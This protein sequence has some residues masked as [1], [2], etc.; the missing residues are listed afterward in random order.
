MS[1]NKLRNRSS[2][3]QR[4]TD[5]RPPARESLSLLLAVTLARPMLRGVARLRSGKEPTVTIEAKAWL[6]SLAC[7][8]AKDLN[9]GTTPLLARHAR[10]HGRPAEGHCLVNL[11]QGALGEGCIEEQAEQPSDAVFIIPM[12]RT[13]GVRRSRR[14]PPPDLPPSCM[15]ARARARP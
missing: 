15:F 9:C 5:Q 11:A 8:K 13:W 2:F 14:R 3:K 10:E 7:G 1:L 12:T 6:T 4:L